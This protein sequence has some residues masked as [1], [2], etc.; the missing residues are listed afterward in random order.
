MKELHPLH[1]AAKEGDFNKIKE[2]IQSGTDINIKSN[3]NDQCVLHFA[4]NYDLAKYDIV[5]YL[6]DH[7]ANVNAADDI[8]TTPL[9]NAAWY[10]HYQIAKKLLDSGAKPNIAG[11]KD[12]RFTTPLNAAAKRKHKNIATLLI[13]YDATY[14]LHD[15]VLLGDYELVKKCI[16][17][18]CD[19]NSV[20]KNGNSSLYL[21]LKNGYKSIFELLAENGAKYNLKNKQLYFGFYH[22]LFLYDDEFA[23]ILFRSDNSLSIHEAIKCG[24]INYVKEMIDTNE[25]PKETL[26]EFLCVAS[27]GG[28]YKLIRYLINIGTDIHH[29]Y[30]GFAPLHWVCLGRGCEDYVL[31]IKRKLSV[32]AELLIEHGADIEL[33]TQ[34]GKETPLKLAEAYNPSVVKVLK[35]HGAK[36]KWWK[37]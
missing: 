13:E 5:E 27:G 35:E 17:K 34:Y 14:T 2:I 1:R 11:T 32:T 22:E 7:G 29:F 26:N 3:L 25:Y 24:A 37:M 36:N 20:D 31:D 10:G 6:I 19:I 33:K 12:A 30:Q 8:N 23:E 9:H 18:G 4:I 28:Q 16:D 21:A 15:V